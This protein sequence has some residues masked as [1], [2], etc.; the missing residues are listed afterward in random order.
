MTTPALL[1]P[2]IFQ[3]FLKIFFLLRQV[4]IVMWKKP[5]YLMSDCLIFCNNTKFFKF[6]IH[7]VSEEV[8]WPKNNILTR[9]IISYLTT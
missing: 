5:K 3:G 8:K 1:P 4:L 2:K 7:A 9:T 6:S